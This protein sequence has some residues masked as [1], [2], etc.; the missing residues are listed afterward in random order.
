MRGYA[1]SEQLSLPT[2]L[3]T[4]ENIFRYGSFLERNVKC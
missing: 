4:R 1:C 3:L 2:G